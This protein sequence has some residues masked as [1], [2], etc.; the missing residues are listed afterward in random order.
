MVIFG[1]SGSASETARA[2]GKK[3]RFAV[4][5]AQIGAAADADDVAFNESIQAGYGDGKRLAYFEF[6]GVGGD[7][8]LFHFNFQI[9][10][11]L[12]Q[13]GVGDGDQD[14]Q[15]LARFQAG[16]YFVVALPG[17]ALL[18]DVAFRAPVD[19]DG[20]TEGGVVLPLRGEVFAPD[21]DGGAGGDA[22]GGGVH[23][24]GGLGEFDFGGCLDAQVVGDFQGFG[25]VGVQELA[26]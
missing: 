20:G 10:G 16:G 5:E 19:G 25:A 21:G 15:A 12:G 3:W 24:Y 17:A 18:V 8:G 6:F 22:P 7:A 14:V 9:L 11:Q 2:I 23:R 1:D 4:V 13:G 26:D